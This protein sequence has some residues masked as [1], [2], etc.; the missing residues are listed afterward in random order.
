[1][2]IS[3]NHLPQLHRKHCLEEVEIPRYY[4]FL[5]IEKLWTIFT[6]FL[7]R[8][9]LFEVIFTSDMLLFF[10]QNIIILSIVL[11]NNF[12]KIFT[13]YNHETQLATLTPDHL[14]ILVDLF[15]SSLPLISPPINQPY[16]PPSKDTTRKM[17]YFFTKQQKPTSNKY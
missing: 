11:A 6:P 17:G 13:H 4:P 2:V 16:L 15:S 1:M 3:S 7:F 10:I 12:Q 5:C 8:R 14:I 9:A